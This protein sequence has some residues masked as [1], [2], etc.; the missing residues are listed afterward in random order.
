MPG[1]KGRPRPESPVGSPYGGADRARGGALGAGFFLSRRRGRGRPDSTP[2]P[3]WAT[4]P[5]IWTASSTPQGWPTFR[6]RFS[7]LSEEKGLKNGWPGIWTF[8]SARRWWHTI[9]PWASIIRGSGDPKT[10]VRKK[11]KPSSK[12]IP[13]WGVTDLKKTPGL[14]AL[15][16]PVA[17]QAAVEFGGLGLHNVFQNQ[18][19]KKAQVD[20]WI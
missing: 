16:L 1:S 3:K 2:P 15:W 17:G 9:R 4:W 19:Y 10:R 18:I 20:T 12:P 11:Y 8:V 7:F 13:H 14:G 6:T 5:S